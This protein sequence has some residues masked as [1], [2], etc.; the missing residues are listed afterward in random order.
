VSQP[1]PNKGKKKA[2]TTQK[3]QAPTIYNTPG[4]S[5]NQP[6]EGRG[7]VKRQTGGGSM[8]ER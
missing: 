4:S 6:A 5:F 7:K 8:E 1:A 3:T 2:T